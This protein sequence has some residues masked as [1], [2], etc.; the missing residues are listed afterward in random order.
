MR[1]C[2]TI[3]ETTDDIY[4]PSPVKYELIV[5]PDTSEE[6]L[7]LLTRELV[8]MLQLQFSNKDQKKLI[9]IDAVENSNKGLFAK[10]W[11][12]AAHSD[13]KAYVEIL[14]EDSQIEREE[15][16]LSDETSVQ[17]IDGLLRYPFCYDPESKHNPKGLAASSI[18]G[19]KKIVCKSPFYMLSMNATAGQ[20]QIN[21]VIL[22]ELLSNHKHLEVFLKGLADN[23]VQEPGKELVLPPSIVLVQYG[24]LFK[25]L[26]QVAAFAKLADD[27]DKLV[28][29]RIQK[30]REAL[31]ADRL[32][33]RLPSVSEGGTVDVTM[34]A[35]EHSLALCSLNPKPRSY[36]T[37]NSSGGTYF[38][39]SAFTV[40]GR[41]AA[42]SSCCTIV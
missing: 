3:A 26:G 10:A 32:F 24:Q 2:F 15:I 34:Q 13:Y 42:N 8:A 38:T 29:E 7:L 41:E 9:V 14:P 39:A 16:I 18:L 19:I 17:F 5:K 25:Q 37:E 35:I 6:A 21:N 31:D 20:S 33:V 27:W 28:N 40:V 4:R 30:A 23:M 1:I 11:H 22:V 36:C 12:K